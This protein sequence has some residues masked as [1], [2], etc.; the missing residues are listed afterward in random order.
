MS[1]RIALVVFKFQNVMLWG[2]PGG[3]S[4]K[5]LPANPGDTGSI[6]GQGGP[7]M[8]PSSQVRVPQLLSLCS[9]AQEPQVLGPRAQDPVLCNTRSHPNEKP[10][11]C[12]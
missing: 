2:F 6:P 10:S 8:P 9:R 5:N 7:H 3:S 12:N 4:V 11:H 1:L